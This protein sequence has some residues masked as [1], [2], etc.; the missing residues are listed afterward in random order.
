VE[1]VAGGVRAVTKAVLFP[2]RFL[3]TLR[4]GQIGHNASAAA[5]Y[6]ARGAH[7][8]LVERALRWR[9]DDIADPAEAVALL[10]QELIGVYDEFFGAYVRDLPSAGVDAPGLVA[11]LEARWKTLQDLAGPVRS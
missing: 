7:R 5:W 3:F 9:E 2:V 10:E 4:T 8:A 11:D 1:L 6:S